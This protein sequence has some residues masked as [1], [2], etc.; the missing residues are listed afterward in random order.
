MKHIKLFEEFTND[1]N[2][3]DTLNE[4]ATAAIVMLMNQVALLGVLGARAGLFD[5]VGDWFSDKI[6]S[7]KSKIRRHKKMKMTNA[8]YQEFA[9]KIHQI[10][11]ELDRNWNA[12]IARLQGQL[13]SAIVTKDSY[14]GDKRRKE[15]TEVANT[16]DRLQREINKLTKKDFFKYIY[17]TADFLEKTKSAS[18][19]LDSVSTEQIQLL[20]KMIRDYVKDGKVKDS[21]WTERK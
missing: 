19:D 10:Y 5:P 18:Q 14:T 13:A 3:N 21:Y 7:I 8:T 12:E 20:A 16:P 6:D 15:W 17:T 11:A 1:S 9:D 2:H 4:D